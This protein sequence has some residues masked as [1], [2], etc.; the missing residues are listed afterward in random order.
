MSISD[1]KHQICRLLKC[2]F[3]VIQDFGE[4][5]HGAIFAMAKIPIQSGAEGHHD[6]TFLLVSSHILNSESV[7]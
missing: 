7:G 2:I 5:R 4:H 6:H 1:E 3:K